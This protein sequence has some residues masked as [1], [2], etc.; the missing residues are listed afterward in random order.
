MAG[1]TLTTVN[2]ILKEIYEG[3]I[4]DQLNE[5][6]NA[7]K[8]LE[9]SSDG[10]TD[11]V[12]GKYVTFP[13]RV[14][15]NS[16]ISYRAEEGLLAPAGQ[17]AYASVQVRL[18]YGYGR[19]RIT[20]P[21][22]ELAD[23]NFQAFAS[24]LDE[25]MNRLKDDLAKDS[26]RI[27]YGNRL[28]NGAIAFIMDAAT[29][30]SHVVDG[31]IQYLQLGEVVDVL[32]AGTGVATGGGSGLTITAIVY[33]T[34]T[35]TLSGS[36]GPTVAG[37]TVAGHA[38]YRTGNRNQEPEGIASIVND[39][40][41]I[42][43]VDPATQPL[44]AAV[45]NRN[46]GTNRPLSEALM[47][48]MCDD[49]RRNGGKVSVILTSLGVRRSYFNLLTQQRRFTDTKSFPGGFQGLPFNYGTEIPVVE[50]VDHPTN[51]MFMLDESKWKVYRKKEWSWAD[52]DNSVLKW[53]VDYDVWQALMRKYW[54]VGITQRNANGNLGD[55]TES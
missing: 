39:T 53:V 24:A 48:K 21:T 43:G 28:S 3:R 37:P 20:G 45:V 35:I 12:G 32:V 18:K 30:A 27:A 29:S 9:K 26:N 36:I 52:E 54:Q 19:I 25:E 16:G 4:Q 50:D 47:I 8:R 14:Q 22:M 46:G 51:Q 34:S 41:Q 11:T 55:I 15:R 31:G 17:Q 38:I 33:T 6:Y 7:L 44:W 42:H 5:E 10:I 49:V 13:I 1:A 40:G 23:S 2:S